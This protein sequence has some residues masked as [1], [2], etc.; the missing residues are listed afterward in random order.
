MIGSAFLLRLG[1]SAN[2]QA[3]FRLASER[4]SATA[5]ELI[6]RT[7]RLHYLRLPT[8]VAVLRT[9]ANEIQNLVQTARLDFPLSASSPS[10]DVRN[11]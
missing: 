9:Y 10:P 3:L 7:T 11:E 2:C 4:L 1:Q 5:G 6:A 8:P